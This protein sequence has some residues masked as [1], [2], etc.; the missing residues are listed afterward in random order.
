[1][2]GA[3]LAWLRAE[4]TAHREEVTPSPGAVAA[5]AGWR[6]APITQHELV[7]AAQSLID[8][9]L[10]DKGERDG[11]PTLRLTAQGNRVAEWN[12]HQPPANTDAAHTSIHITGGLSGTM[13][14]SQGSPHA[15]QAGA[16]HGEDEPGAQRRHRGAMRV[17]LAT[18]AV[19]AVG[20][21][22]AVLAWAPWKSG[23]GAASPA[24]PTTTAA[25]PT[26]APTTTTTTTVTT[27]PSTTPVPAKQF[28]ADIIGT[29]S[30]YVGTS[31]VNGTTYPHSIA[32]RIGG[33]NADA[34]HVFNLGR[35]WNQFTAVIGLS[36]GHDTKSVVRFEVYA[37]DNLIYTSDNIPVGQS[38]T[39]TVPITGVLNL[40]LRYLFV[41]GDMGLCSNAGYAVWAD[42]AVSK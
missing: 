19:G 14:L 29:T 10:A 38:P 11:H 35:K 34:N 9:R 3:L 6:A 5:Q 2:R 32:G 31:D 39:I 1:M 17:A 4:T 27:T 26:A 18:L 12:S 33:C 13:N 24:V 37:D 23:P 28:L 15:R 42:A 20:V 22:V 40:K 25:L 30:W 16:P 8:D 36:D 41:Q 7:E 21:L